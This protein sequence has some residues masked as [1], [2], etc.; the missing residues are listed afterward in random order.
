[1]RKPDFC[2]CEN[3]GADQLCSNCEADQRLCFRY[4]DS[5][6]FFFFLKLKF[7]SSRLFLKLYRPVCVRPGGKPQSP[8]FS[9]RGS[10]YNGV[11]TV[12]TS[13]NL[14]SDTNKATQPQKNAR[15]WKFRIKKVEGLYSGFALGGKSVLSDRLHSDSIK[16]IL[17]PRD[18]LYLSS[19]VCTKIH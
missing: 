8:I 4:T 18:T 12:F 6:I 14:W 2:L 9:R 16:S 10:K 17:P 13:L 5:T 1:M 11:Y 15:G 7:Q 19:H 3:K